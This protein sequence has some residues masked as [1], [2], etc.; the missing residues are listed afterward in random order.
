MPHRHQINWIVRQANT[1]FKE[2]EHTVTD[3]AI[4]I[5][6]KRKNFVAKS[7]TGRQIERWL[8]RPPSRGSLFQQHFAYFYLMSVFYWN[9]VPLCLQNA[10]ILSFSLHCES[11]PREWRFIAFWFRFEWNPF[12]GQQPP[13]MNN[14][15]F[16]DE[17]VIAENADWNGSEIWNALNEFIAYF[18][19]SSCYCIWFISDSRW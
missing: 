2:E 8:C 12:A 10:F 16:A 1:L 4:Y 14:V 18:V 9:A 13:R 5:F 6:I 15:R 7:S 19:L 11:K 17:Q 3:W